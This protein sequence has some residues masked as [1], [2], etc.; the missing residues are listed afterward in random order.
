[1]AQKASTDNIQMNK[2]AVLQYKI[3]FMNTNIWILHYFTC[4]EIFLFFWFFPQPFKNV[5]NIISL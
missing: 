1:M 2:F 4:Y 3:L 5:K